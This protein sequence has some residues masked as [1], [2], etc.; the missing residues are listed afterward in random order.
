MLKKWRKYEK[1]IKQFLGFGLITSF[2]LTMPLTSISCSSNSNSS[3]NSKIVD[4]SIFNFSYSY[5]HTFQDKETNLD[6][7]MN[8]T[9]W[10]Y[11]ELI[12]FKIVSII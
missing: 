12:F 2:S 6:H 9:F 11:N 3:N 1:K 7:I 5:I 8:N 10:S 4:S